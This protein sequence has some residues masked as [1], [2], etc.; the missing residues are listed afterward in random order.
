VLANHMIR[1]APAEFGTG[2][3]I[4]HPLNVEGLARVPMAPPPALGQHSREIL[5]DLGFDETAI[6]D[7]AARGVI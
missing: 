6:A 3:I 2:P 4:D 7:L 5:A 1:E